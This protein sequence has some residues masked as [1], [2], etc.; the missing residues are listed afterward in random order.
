MKIIKL[1]TIL[2]AVAIF[3]SC[4][5]DKV[6]APDNSPAEIKTYVETHFS[7]N[8]I[9]QIMQDKE[10]IS[11]EYQ[12]ILSDLTRLD[13][14]RKFEIQDIESTNALP[15]SVIPTELSTYVKNNF[16]QA[17]IIRWEL[18]DR[19]QQINLNNGLDLVFDKS[20]NFLRIDD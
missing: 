17:M 18:E 12:V 4:E 3:T 7:G 9:I 15:E 5:K 16:P 6:I 1:L 8:S 13:F 2:A 14:N 19:H 20:G 10:L 11:S